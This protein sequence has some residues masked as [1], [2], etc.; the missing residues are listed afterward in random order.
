MKSIKR[1]F[2]ASIAVLAISIQI[3]DVYAHGFPFAAPSSR[4]SIENVC[5]A[6]SSYYALFKEQEEAG[7]A[8]SARQVQYIVDLH[9][10]YDKVMIEPV[11][12]PYGSA[13]FDRDVI[14]AAKARLDNCG[15]PKTIRCPLLT[16][17]LSDFP[18]TLDDDF[19]GAS[20]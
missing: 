10:I 3:P 9:L 15:K 6:N 18:V 4:P 17:S 11:H 8:C 20:E 7:S 19:C 12:N 1:L 14:C 5:E 2:I 13:I 16:Y